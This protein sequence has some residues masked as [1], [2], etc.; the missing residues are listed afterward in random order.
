MRILVL[1]A[2]TIFFILFLIGSLI[3]GYLRGRR[4]AAILAIQALI[5]F[6]L[7]VLLYIITVKNKASDTNI[8]NIINMFMGDGGLQRR[9]GVSVENKC[10]TDILIEYIPKQ[11]NYGDGLYFVFAENG[12]YLNALVSQVYNLIFA[13]LFILVYLGFVF[14]FYL[15]YLVLY[16]DRR[17]FR[18]LRRKLLEK[19]KKFE[20]RLQE[21]KRR[22]KKV[23]SKPD[24]VKREDREDEALEET[25]DTDVDYAL[26][27]EEA[28]D[29]VSV[30]SIE[31]VPEGEEVISDLDKKGND[32][33]DE[34]SNDP[35]LFKKLK[36]VRVTKK[37]LW[38]MAIQGVRGL[39][40]SIFVLA[41]VGSLLFIM[42]GTGKRQYG[43][44]DLKGTEYEKAFDAYQALG[45]Y[46]TAGIYSVLNSITDKNDFPYYLYLV[47]LVYRH[48]VD[49]QDLGKVSFNMAAELNAYSNFTRS[50]IDLAF[51]YEG[52]R[53]KAVV[54]G[55]TDYQM[56]DVMKDLFANEAFRTEF[57]TL[58]DDFEGGAY[59]INMGLSFVTS[60]ANHMDETNLK[61]TIGS[62]AYEAL[63]ILFKKGYLSSYIPDELAKKQAL[64]INPNLE[65]EDEP[66]ISA[67]SLLTKEDTKNL[68][69]VIFDVLSQETT[70]DDTKDILNYSKLVI[71]EIKKLSILNSERKNEMNPVLKRLYTY[72]E[73]RYLEEAFIELTPK[74]LKLEK[75]FKTIDEI[76][77]DLDDDSIDWISEIEY[78]LDVAYD[79][80][81]LYSNVYDPNNSD[82][83]LMFANAFDPS[84]SNRELNIQLLNKLKNN[85]SNSK[86]LDKVLSSNGVYET[87]SNVLSN[88]IYSD[89]YLK[90]N[91]T[92]VNTY[93]SNGNII[94]YG[95][96]YKLIQG[97]TSILSNPNEK[98][99]LEKIST[100]S[101]S[102][103]KDIIL[104]LGDVIDILGDDIDTILDSDILNSLLS[105]VILA[106]RNI[107]E[108]LGLSLY[109][110]EDIL[111]EVDGIHVNLIKK[112][113]VSYVFDALNDLIYPLSNIIDENNKYYNDYDYLITNVDVDA[114]NSSTILKGTIA[115]LLISNLTNEA[116][117]DY[118][119][120]PDEY[121]DVSYWVSNDEIVSI[122]DAIKNT[123]LKIGTLVKEYPSSSEQLAAITAMLKGL[124][125]EDITTI[126]A[127]DILYIAIANIINNPSI[128]GGSLL[129]PDEV[130][131]NSSFN[132]DGEALYTISKDELSSLFKAVLKLDLDFNNLSSLDVTTIINDLNNI[133]DSGNTNLDYCYQSLIITATINDKLN[134]ISNITI[135][136]SVKNGNSYTLN[137]N[138]YHA[139]SKDE[140]STLID[141]V[142]ELNIDLNNTSDLKIKLTEDSINKASLS[143]II[144]ATLISNLA[145]IDTLVIPNIVLDNEGII[146]E[147]E[148]KNVLNLLLEHKTLFFGNN[149]IDDMVSIDSISF[150]EDNIKLSILKEM[151][152]KSIIFNATI[153][154]ILSSQ[155]YIVMPDNYKATKE[156]LIINYS[157]LDIVNNNEVSKIFNSL[158]ILIGN[159]AL[160]K[161]LGNQD[162]LMSKINSIDTSRI[163]EVLSSSIIYL[164]L[165]DT[166]VNN[167]PSGV[168]I[169]PDEVLIDS[170]FTVNNSNYTAL[171]KNEIN[172]LLTSITKLNIDFTNMDDFN[173]MDIINNLNNK[174]LSNKTNLDYCYDSLI[175]R[176]TISDAITNLEFISKPNSIF[177][178]Q[179]YTVDGNIN[180]YVI[181]NEIKNLVNALISL[182]IDLDSID[183]SLTIKLNEN[184]ISK[185]VLSKILRATVTEK[186]NSISTIVIPNGVLDSDNSITDTEL[187][188]LLNI[189]ASNKSLFFSDIDN[190]FVSLSSIS[191]DENNI[192]LSI[193]KEMQEESIIFN[194][195]IMNTLIEGEY[196]VLPKGYYVTKNE[197]INDYKNISFVVNDE[198]EYIFNSLVMIFGKDANISAL[199]SASANSIVKSL[200][201]TTIDYIYNSEI[202]PATISSKLENITTIHIPYDAYDGTY[203]DIDDMVHMIVDKNEFK[204]LLNVLNSESLNLNLDNVDLT[205][206]HLE[207]GLNPNTD[208]NVLK[209]SKSKILRATIYNTLVNSVSDLVIPMSLRTGI[210]NSS[211]DVGYISED[212]LYDLLYE[213]T[214]N[215]VVLGLA[216]TNTS[217]I[218]VSSI[219]INVNSLNVDV[220][221]EMI[222]SDV[223]KATSIDKLQ[224]ITD[225]IV[226]NPYYNEMIDIKSFYGDNIN[227]VI[228]NELENLL[229]GVKALNVS[230]LD[231]LEA[232]DYKDII[233]TL[234]S[235]TIDKIYQS[236][237]LSYTI[238][239]K[240]KSLKKSDNTLLINIPSECL[241][242]NE[243]T[244]YDVSKTYYLIEKNEFKAFV[245]GI[246]DLE[247]DLTND[248]FLSLVTI[249][250]NKIL[251]ITSSK[252]LS[253]IVSDN[254]ISNSDIYVPN[255]V[256]TNDQI[257]A[258]E[259]KLFLTAVNE[260]LGITSI[261]IDTS[262]IKP[263]SIISKDDFLASMIMRATVTSLVDSD[264]TNIYIDTND[265]I[266][267][268][269]YNYSYNIY[270]LSIDELSYLLDI[271]GDEESFELNVTIS[272]IMSYSDDDIIMVLKSSIFRIKISKIIIDNGYNTLMVNTSS[273]T[274]STGDTYNFNATSIPNKYKF[275]DATSIDSYDLE[276]ISSGVCQVNVLTDLDVLAYK[277]VFTH[278]SE[279][280]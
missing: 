234:D 245:A 142:I 199:S 253:R 33:R 138:L 78:L 273:I 85:I 244:Y 86:L 60:F 29:G 119:I 96:L 262:N 252:I 229:N 192:K 94:E 201:D 174:D 19:T 217:P 195:T 279:F 9:L 122:V 112:E 150:D 84:N 93:D 14:I 28:I 178:S 155:E 46:G 186:I 76:N 27:R 164:T 202:M 214:N 141:A 219:N 144:R 109:V 223:I 35:Y 145:N 20:G 17:H 254:I 42:G 52:E 159:D 126:L 62:D 133:D 172:S 82:V 227:F 198:M 218:N 193:L 205:S 25:L 3:T 40:T 171:T 187:Q 270:V 34:T 170:G 131:V 169:I 250:S 12:S 215:R 117:K 47:D 175:I 212:A 64:D 177:T 90:N 241:I 99:L 200:N 11:M 211:G 15:L 74:S 43:E 236:V 79:S 105:G 18:R 103:P 188:N 101:S 232:I 53:I 265:V 168:L 167:I 31:E 153:I 258:N 56:P 125:E 5:S 97:L 111:Q 37:R 108:S 243:S 247:I 26:K 49:D 92:Y 176:S 158:K 267:T 120:L 129:V 32:L 61:D 204:A 184:T 124:D 4:K 162:F 190:D 68:V 113:E 260:G 222:T 116:V 173:I 81:N 266:I 261:N 134:T 194:A 263:S 228:N 75:N 210:Y 59:F 137:N 197:I 264:E 256:V 135:P 240:I 67:R 71:P 128:T 151:Q 233:P 156:E 235:N 208:D 207:T 30:N 22:R 272:D 104:F 225:L 179:S 136:E 95:E 100:I 55:K 157:N 63:A 45:E 271:I 24:M 257:N 238:T 121:L 213:I 140:L 65:F 110:P 276:N 269:R 148:F 139:I 196:V 41:L 51:K 251:S 48:N 10:L 89:S 239:D 275:N 163:D 132:L 206:L 36:K 58:I 123:P 106:N 44:N 83:L 146:N 21:R 77:N 161:D 185:L 216:E 1:Y 38:G 8:V 189:I 180:H 72:L 280:M 7:T 160:I 57:D 278:I 16:P 147:D 224:L 277:Y 221:L 268:S 23:N 181:K 154:N 249:D 6:G 69:N 87:L 242:A 70:G 259:L 118:V 166:I 274:L 255:T 127:S 98:V 230:T 114:L 248:N 66:Y 115:N 152:E 246:K 143:K 130:L 220:I 203:I 231:G 102:E 237:I 183:E 50:T 209:I 165:S 107:D 191:F 54:A 88:Y 80:I 73:N 2:P 13:I 226:I 39:I 149:I 182:D 91:I